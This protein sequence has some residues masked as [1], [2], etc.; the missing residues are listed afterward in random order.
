MTPIEL[1]ETCN[2]DIKQEIFYKKHIEEAQSKMLK[3][4]NFD[5]AIRFYEWSIKQIEERVND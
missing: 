1:I 2:S 5:D 3:R 4:L